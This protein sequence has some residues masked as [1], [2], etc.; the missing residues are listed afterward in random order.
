MHKH[1]HTLRIFGTRGTVI[2]DDKGAR[3]HRSRGP[4]SRSTR[5]LWK[6]LP[7]SKGELVSD[8]ASLINGGTAAR[9]RVVEREL[10]LATALIA[11]DRALKTGRREKVK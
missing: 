5:L 8:F 7:A 2:V 11:S 4:D 3:W 6:R 10:S 9:R 1:Q